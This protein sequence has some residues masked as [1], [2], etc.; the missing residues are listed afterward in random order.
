M[1]EEELT[2]NRVMVIAAHPDDPEFGCAGTVAR[3]AAEGKEV[4]YC[5]VT[6]GDVGTRDETITPGVLASLREKEQRAAAQELGVKDVVFL[7]HHDGMVVNDMHLRREL[8]HILRQYQPDVVLTIDPWRHYQMHP[9]HRAAGQAA[10]DAIYAARER[11][12]FPEQLVNGTKPCRPKAAFLF[13][14]ENADYYVD[15]SST[16]DRRLAAL[17]KHESQIGHRND[18]EERIR[19][20]AR[21][22]G[23]KAGMEYAEGLKKITLG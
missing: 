18:I 16:I 4:Y 17:K 20:G 23:Q 9:D 15:I 12:I 5:L 7:H 2:F 3:W 10:L 19:K 22:I 14:T 6:S 1:A 13:W 8:A 21:E 11:L